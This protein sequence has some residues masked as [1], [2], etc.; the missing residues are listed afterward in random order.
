VKIFLKTGDFLIEKLEQIWFMVLIAAV[1][2][3]LEMQFEQMQLKNTLYRLKLLSV[4][5]VVFNA[6]NWPI[7]IRNADVINSILFQKVFIA[8]ICQLFV[9]V[10]FFLLTGVFSRKN[11]LSIL[12]F[13]CYSLIILFFIISA[14][15]MIF[16]EII[17]VLQIYF[18]C[19]FLYT[20]VPDFKPKIFI[21]FL[22]LWYFTFLSL[23]TY[24]NNLF[25]FGDAQIFA[26]NIFL[27]VLV[28]K[29]F[30]YNSKVRKF[31]N[32]FRINALN[33]KLESLSMTDELTKLNN[34]RSFLDYMNIIWKQSRRLQLPINV[35]M[36][37]I[38]Y[39]KKLNDSLG[40][41][42]GDK[43]LIR[44]AQC[45][46]NQLKRDTDFI[47]RFGGEEFVCL[48]PYIGKEDAANFAKDLV[49]SVENIKIRHP[50]SEC[51]EYVTIS[52]GMASTIPDE[53][54][55]LTQ[56]LDEAD[57]ALYRAKHSGRNRVAD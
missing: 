42:E 50:M 30:Q 14:Y 43:A 22:A 12:W 1:P 9:T 55:S 33:E 15:T 45:M 24:K 37:D 2:P 49:Q 54:S 25:K 13:M 39:F 53:Y 47:A 41:L 8:D 46:K 16:S 10:L 40:H 52:I 20:F 56:L 44:I 26:L 48:L 18:T 31:I 23:L 7:Y 17:L 19:T 4:I 32:T 29:V 3:E 38:D 21:S 5:T 51:S 11:R 28:I 57:K 6:L 27:I 35:L 36:I 34:R